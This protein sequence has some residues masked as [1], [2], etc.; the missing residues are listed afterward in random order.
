MQRFLVESCLTLTCHYH[1]LIPSHKLM[2]L[3][4]YVDDLGIVQIK[5]L[6]PL[7]VTYNDQSPLENHHHAAAVRLLLQPEHRYLPVS[8][9][10]LMYVGSRGHVQKQLLPTCEHACVSPNSKEQQPQ[11]SSANALG[12]SLETE[13]QGIPP[14]A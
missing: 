13:A 6:H 8:L 12:S 7:A 11:K 10:V 5:T 9:P 1:C 14:K 2:R 3:L 4:R